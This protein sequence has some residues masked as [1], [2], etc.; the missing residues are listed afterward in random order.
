VF[1]RNWFSLN[2]L[3]Q[4]A[5]ASVSAGGAQALVDLRAE[6]LQ[7]SMTV[8]DSLNEAAVDNPGVAFPCLLRC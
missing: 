8:Q 1:S 2:N 5:E 4:V 6:L 3:N 7:R